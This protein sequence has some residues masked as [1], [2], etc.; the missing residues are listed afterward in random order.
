MLFLQILIHNTHSILV[1]IVSWCSTAWQN[2]ECQSSDYEFSETFSCTQSLGQD[3]CSPSPFP[4]LG[5]KWSLASILRIWF[6]WGMPTPQPCLLSESCLLFIVRLLSQMF[7]SHGDWHTPDNWLKL[8]F[9][10]T[11]H[12]WPWAYRLIWENV[13][14][15]YSSISRYLV[16]GSIFRQYWL[17]GYQ[18]R[19]QSYVFCL[20]K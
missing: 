16:V 19:Y 17:L 12:F 7:F 4:S 3:R 6:L 9:P 15:I 8:L 14:C 5:N 13:C 2:T 20:K 18:N 1:W 11:C 10:L